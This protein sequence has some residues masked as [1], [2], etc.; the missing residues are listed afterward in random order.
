MKQVFACSSF[1]LPQYGHFIVFT[2]DTWDTPCSRFLRKADRQS[3]HTV[4]TA[5][6]R[7]TSGYTKIPGIKNTPA[8]DMNPAKIQCTDLEDEYHRYVPG[9]KDV[10][11]DFP[12]TANLTSALRT[13]WESCVSAAETAFASGKATWFEINIPQ[14]GSF[15]FAGMPN[16]LGVNEM[17]VDAVIESTLHVVPNQIAG[18]ANAS[19]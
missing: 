16:E 6:T 13:A 12:F 8:I 18:W 9:V 1:S 15:F 3:L 17:G 10:G 4:R 2:S 11:D 7:P 19:T 5:G 14:F